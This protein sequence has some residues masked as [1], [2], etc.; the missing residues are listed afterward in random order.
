MRNG[1]RES[2]K[3]SRW[4]RQVAGWKTIG[5]FGKA[6]FSAWIACWTNFKLRNLILRRKNV[7]VQNDRAQNNLGR[8]GMMNTKLEITTPSDTEIAMKRSFN[9]PRRLVFDALTKPEL[10]SR[11]MLGPP[12]WTMPV[13]EIDL[14]VGGEFRFVWSNGDTNM[15][16][17]GVYRE[18]VAPEKIVNSEKFDQAWYPGEA[19]VTNFLVERDKKTTLTLTVRYESRET[20]DIV[21]K[22]P[23]E[24]GVSA[25]Y[26]RLDDLLASMASSEKETRQ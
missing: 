4:R 24:Q 19:M 6:G 15:G 5:S 13:C 1:V 16:M 9:A 3:R 25:G 17:G 18:I 14:R 2:W 10:V 23:M 26:D 8:P 7:D 22:S 21:L 20:R 12:G 11:W